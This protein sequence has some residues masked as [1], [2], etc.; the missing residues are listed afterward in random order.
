M[1]AAQSPSPAGARIETWSPRRFGAHLD[2]A[3]QIYARAMNYPEYT[4][5]Q[6]GVSARKHLTPRRA[7]ACRP[8][9]STTGTLVGFGYGYT[10]QARPVVARPGSPRTDPRDGRSSG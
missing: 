9:F 8:P 5:T 6:R 7:F 10:S 2:E 4:G 3:M 1:R